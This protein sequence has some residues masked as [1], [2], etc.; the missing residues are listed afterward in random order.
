LFEKKK[1]WRVGDVPT[2]KHPSFLFHDS[3]CCCYIA[4]FETLTAIERVPTDDEDHPLQEIK[5]TGVTIFVNPYKDLLVEEERKK[6][7]KKKAAEKKEGIAPASEAEA[8]VREWFS[9]P[10]G[11]PAG[12]ARGSG[13]V[14]KYLSAAPAVA[15]EGQQLKKK[16]KMAGGFGNFDAW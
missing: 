12:E 1:G 8:E 15:E 2:G 5:I 16:A 10:A 3:P 6:T 9:N 7:A 11:A 14:G 13:P 4:G